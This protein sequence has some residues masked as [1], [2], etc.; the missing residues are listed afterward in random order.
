MDTG[1]GGELYNFVVVIDFKKVT[2]FEIGSFEIA[3]SNQ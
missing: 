1:S 3:K 2:K